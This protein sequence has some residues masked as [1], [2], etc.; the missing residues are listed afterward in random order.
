[1]WLMKYLSQKFIKIHKILKSLLFIVIMHCTLSPLFSCSSNNF[2]QILGFTRMKYLTTKFYK[3]SF[4]HHS[5]VFL[6]CIIIGLVSI[7][8]LISHVHYYCKHGCVFSLIYIYI[9][10][11]LKVRK[12]TKKLILKVLTVSSNSR[13]NL[14]SN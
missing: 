2:Y 10:I 7:F 12:E 5:Y 11:Q 8:I 4:Y 9:Y 1:M 3:D 6:Y 13:Y 14:Q